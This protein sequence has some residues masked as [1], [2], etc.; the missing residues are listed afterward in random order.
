MTQ[1]VLI[2]GSVAYDTIMVFEGHFKDHILPDRVHML[3][4]S[5]LAPRLK[6][7][8]GGCAANIAYNL[9]GLG[10]YPVVLATV[11]R[12][13]GD[14]LARLEAMGIDTA[15]VVPMHDHYTAQAFIT[16]D[17]SDNQINAFHPGAMAH[18][19]TVSASSALPAAFGIVAPNGK[20]AML[21]HARQFREAGVPF[22]FDP[23]QGLPMF[24]GAELRGLI[25][26]ATAVAVNDYESGMLAER[27]G[28]SEAEIAARVQ[29]LI[30]TLGAEGAQVWTGGRCTSIPACPVAEA[31]DP[32]GCGDAFR[33]GLL[34]GLSQGWDWVKAAR[35]GSVM[36]A[37]KIEHQGA[38]N[39]PVDRDVVAARHEAAYGE[40][41]W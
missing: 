25:E 15:H 16:T 5:F 14:Y 26:G 13:A 9:K 22:V 24:D 17:L 1:R 19:H 29:A 35:L 2:S 31:V 27:T 38:Q 8:F 37:L 41:P 28:W 21:E 18:A 33:G 40:R 11:G 34:F 10:G 23:G 36:G 32:T 7:E 4:V 30:V 20:Q 12:D 6:R 39:H 3:N